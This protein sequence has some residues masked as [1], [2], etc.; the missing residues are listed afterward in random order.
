MPYQR[1]TLQT[2]ASCLP[3]YGVA[4][5]RSH[6]SKMWSTFKLEVRLKCT[7]L[8]LGCHLQCIRAL[9]RQQVFQPIDSETAECALET[10]QTLIRVIYPPVDSDVLDEAPEGLG[11]HIVGECLEVLKEPEKS[12]AKPAIK[13]MAALVETTRQF[14]AGSG[15]LFLKSLTWVSRVSFHHSLHHLPDDPTPH[16]ALPRPSRDNES[17]SNSDSYGVYHS[18]CP[19]H[20]RTAQ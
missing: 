3:V 9:V 1:D 5:S 11:Q 20:L 7:F 17:P 15:D 18:S 12:K 16:P 10:I 13:V 6:A 8:R 2:I 4:V 19:R 14:D